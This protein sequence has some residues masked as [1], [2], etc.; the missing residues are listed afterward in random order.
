M[1]NS[2][3]AR[4]SSWAKATRQKKGKRQDQTTDFA[5]PV[6]AK[7]PANLT[8]SAEAVYS[9]QRTAHS[10]ALGLNQVHQQAEQGAAQQHLDHSALVAKQRH[11][12]GHG[13][14]GRGQVEVDPKAGR[15]E[16]VVTEEQRQVD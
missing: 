4:V 14:D 3:N 9:G 12:G 13:D 11:G 15:P 5:S 1:R 6:P 7:Y 2:L 10:Q 16:H 8:N